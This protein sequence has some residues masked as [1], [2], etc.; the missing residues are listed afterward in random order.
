MLLLL[1]VS[2]SLCQKDCTGVECP[3]LNSCIEEV[4]ESGA[5]CAT[6]LQTGCKCEGYQYYDCINA[7]FRSGRVPEGESYFVDFGSTECSC[8]QGGGRISCHFIPCPELPA[9]CIEVSEPADGCI[10]CERIGCAYE[11]QKYEAGHSFRLDQDCQVCHCPHNGG[12]LMCSPI[13]DCDPKQVHKPML[14]TTTEESA[15]WR[16][17]NKIQNLF[18]NQGSRS[19][20]SKPFP[21]SYHDSLSPFKPT[22]SDMDEEEEEEEEEDYDYPTTDSSKQPRRDL[23]SPVESVISVFDLEKNPLHQARGPKQELKERFG[24]HEAT[25]DRPRFPLREERTDG[26]KYNS[27]KEIKETDKLSEDN[28]KGPQFNIPMA[29]PSK[30]KIPIYRDST[31][32]KQFSIYRA[33]NVKANF[34]PY[35]DRSSTE[36]HEVSDRN[37]LRKAS[38]KTFNETTDSNE[39]DSYEETTYGKVVTDSP[40]TVVPTIPQAQ[41]EEAQTTTTWPTTEGTNSPDHIYHSTPETR[42]FYSTQEQEVNIKKQSVTDSNRNQIKDKMVDKLEK[43]IQYLPTSQSIPS[44]EQASTDR[45]FKEQETKPDLKPELDTNPHVIFSPTSQTPL[46]VKEENEHLLNKQS[47]SLF[48][49]AEEEEE[50]EKEEREE[51]DNTLSSNAESREGEYRPV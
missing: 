41:T 34:G 18:S 50:E 8:P 23:A 3:I 35:K 49:G 12:N 17:R 30:E 29:S 16:R 42:D 32:E 43:Y 45:P 33:A 28:I 10:Q 37:N 40:G 14:A 48:E 38:E 46:K 27:H 11:G 5:C 19:P 9:N 31:H 51:K 24:V 39:F 47:Q 22:P 2:E 25:S 15:P 36:V 13:P 44:S 20:F 6:C 26:A 1:C 7:G 21:Q 4:L